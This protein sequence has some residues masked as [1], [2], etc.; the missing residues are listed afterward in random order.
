M[1]FLYSIWGLRK[2]IL[3]FQN[4]SFNL[5]Y[6]KRFKKKVLIYGFPIISFSKGSRITVGNRF[7]I[8]SSSYFSEP[9]INHPTIIRLLSNESDLTIG[10]NVGISGG[11]ICVQNKVSIGNNVLLGANVFITDTDF[12]PIDPLNRRFSKEN[13]KAKEVSIG[14]NVFIGMDSIVLKGISIGDNSIVA[15]GSVV[16]KSIPANQIWGGNPVRYI[17]DL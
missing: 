8:C 10:D 9:G 4:I 7:V 1:D 3:V 13:I 17:R 14:N 15:A 5:L 6:S 12:H 16:S 11:G 2:L